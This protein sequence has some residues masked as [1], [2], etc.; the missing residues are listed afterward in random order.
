MDNA[1]F[2]LAA[3]AIVGGC[4]VVVLYV[5]GGRFVLASGRPTRRVIA[6]ASL[7]LV[8]VAA[9]VLVVA[10]TWSP[11]DATPR[12]RASLLCTIVSGLLGFSSA[13]FP[14]ARR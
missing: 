5:R 8:V 6:Y 10:E 9:G 12:L 3:A 11:H 7:A 1:T 13:L 14:E 4:V 2:V